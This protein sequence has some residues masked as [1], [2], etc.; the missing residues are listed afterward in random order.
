M[1]NLLALRRILKVSRYSKL[2][3]FKLKKSILE[4]E[5]IKQSQELDKLAD[6]LRN[7]DNSQK[8]CMGIDWSADTQAS[9][10]IVDSDG[11][12]SDVETDRP[13]IRLRSNG[14]YYRR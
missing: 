8:M 12:A 9:V 2:C 7:N 3:W 5:I 14:V 10:G 1:Q 4:Y 13:V 6:L 11:T